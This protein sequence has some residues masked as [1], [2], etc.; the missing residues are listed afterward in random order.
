LHHISNLPESLGTKFRE[1]MSVLKVL[2]I[3]WAIHAARAS[4]PHF[5]QKKIFIVFSDFIGEI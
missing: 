5:V 1:E 2:I 4:Q 3:S